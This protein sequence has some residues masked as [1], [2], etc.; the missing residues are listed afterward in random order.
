[1]HEICLQHCIGAAQVNSWP[2]FIQFF[3][4]ICTYLL[5]FSIISVRCFVLGFVNSF[6]SVSV[7]FISVPSLEMR[8]PAGQM[9]TSFP[10]H[11]FCVLLPTV[12]VYGF[13]LLYR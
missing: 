9:K 3:T 1:M 5:V 7:Y 8:D 10:M 4:F 12:T 2:V 11:N 13:C 6:V